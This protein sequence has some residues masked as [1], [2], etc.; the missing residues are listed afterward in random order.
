MPGNAPPRYLQPQHQR[1]ECQRA[2]CGQHDGND[3]GDTHSMMQASGAQLLQVEHVLH[4]RPSKRHG[5][6]DD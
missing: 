4:A 5:A 1:G 2:N 3:R 6:E